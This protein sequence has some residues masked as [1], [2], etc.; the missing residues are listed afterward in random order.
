MGTLPAARRMPL[1]AD[2]D[3]LIQ[4]YDGGTISAAEL[5]EN[6]RKYRTSP[7]SSPTTRT[8]QS[9]RSQENDQPIQTERLPAA[10]ALKGWRSYDLGK[11]VPVRLTTLEPLERSPP[12]LLATT[13]GHRLSVH[14]KTRV[15]RHWR[16]N[17]P[18]ISTTPS[19]VGSLSVSER[20]ASGVF[21]L[22]IELLAACNGITH[23]AD[24]L[25]G[26][27]ETFDCAA[28]GI[29]G[30]DILAISHHD[31]DSSQSALLM[32]DDGDPIR[33]TALDMFVFIECR[34]AVDTPLLEDLWRR[35]KHLYDHDGHRLQW[36]G[37]TRDRVRLR[38]PEISESE[39]DQ[40]ASISQKLNR[41]AYECCDALRTD[42]VQNDDANIK[43]I[44]HR[45][46]SVAD[47]IMLDFPG[48]SQSTI[49]R[50]FMAAWHF[51]R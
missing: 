10:V 35:R 42:Q 21:K 34:F 2:P 26:R 12:Y 13:S 24:I 3:L 19:T 44:R 18:E 38:Y 17:P 20:T 46:I 7:D 45:T 5:I 33:P 15:F 6:W 25:S 49:D 16:M 39:L 36:A 4:L 9:I 31:S 14:P 28:I 27:G 1:F 51:S 11:S 50:L 43:N 22:P 32:M 41:L 47:Q 37:G 40:M 29:S 30:G 8:L 48:L 23:V